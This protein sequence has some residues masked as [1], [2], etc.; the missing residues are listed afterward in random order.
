MKVLVPESLSQEGLDKLRTETEVEARKLS[1]DELLEAI[2]DFD[3]LIV[4]SATRV[5]RELLERA[6]SLKVVGRAGVG[7][8]NIDVAAA[9]RLGIQVVNAPASNVLSAA[10]HTLA[11][12]LALA[13]HIPAA[14][15]SLRAGGWERERFTGVELE[16][17]TLGILGLGRIGTLVAERAAGFGMKLLGYDPYVS[18][19][20]ATQRGIQIQM[21]ATV[22][23]V[24]READFITVHLPKN[25]ETKAILADPERFSLRVAFA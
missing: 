3:A 22:E 25:A 5:D 7:L 6:T 23:E 21:A 17:K 11:L 18:R 15:A 8:D 1:R 10:E 19:Q 12:L 9:T 16:G 13:R 14:D 2:G 24:C 4:R 20:W